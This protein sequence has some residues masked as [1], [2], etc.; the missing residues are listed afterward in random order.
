MSFQ[1]EDYESIFIRGLNFFDTYL[2]SLKFE[3]QSHKSINEIFTKRKFIQKLTIA[4][5]KK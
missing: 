4:K 1:G 3:A 5:S 2:F